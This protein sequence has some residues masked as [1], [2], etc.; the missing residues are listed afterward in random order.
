[1]YNHARSASQVAVDAGQAA[2]RVVPGG[3]YY[4]GSPLGEH[5]RQ[6]TGEPRHRVTLTS[7]LEV[8]TT[9]VLRRHFIS[10]MKYTPVAK[11]AC[12]SACAVDNVNWHEAAAYCNALTDQRKAGAKCYSCSSSGAAVT[13]AEAAGF[14]G[15]SAYACPGYRLPTEAEWEYLYRADVHT[16]YSNGHNTKGLC[17]GADTL[18]SHIAWYDQTASGALQPPALKHP[19][20]WGL[21]DLAGSLAE[22]CHD[23]HQPNPGTAPLTNPVGS[24]SAN[25]PSR[26]GA[27]SGSAFMTRAAY[28]GFLGLAMRGGTTGFR[29]VRS[30][31]PTCP[32]TMTLVNSGA[33][34]FC[35]DPSDSAGKSRTEAA[36][37]CKA[38]GAGGRICSSTDLSMAAAAGAVKTTKPLATP[39][40]GSCCCQCGGYPG[41]DLTFWHPTKPT[42]CG[43]WRSDFGKSGVNHRCCA[44]AK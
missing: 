26:G 31:K 11:S 44:D 43:C 39:S 23:P 35:V 32:G 40:V 20:R 30:V 4:M 25:R 6:S 27:W 19:N 18:A 8:G 3:A 42:Y 34:L 16:A 12:G 7:A 2:F 9:E 38:R 36:K 24:G 10:L 22:W 13:C 15:K 1:M 14:K 21:Y 28:R 5:C 33:V 29:C 41:Q 17:Q 37:A